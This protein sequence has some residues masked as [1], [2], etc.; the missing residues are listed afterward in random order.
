MG[1]DEHFR[2][3][4]GGAGTH[5]VLLTVVDKPGARGSDTEP[6]TCAQVQLRVRFGHPLLG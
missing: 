1:T 6:V 4:T 3:E 5:H 2:V